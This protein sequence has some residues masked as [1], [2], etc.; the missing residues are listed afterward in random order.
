MRKPAR[1]RRSGRA[2]GEHRCAMRKAAMLTG[3]A[4]LG[5]GALVFL[6]VCYL[7]VAGSLAGNL[8]RVVVLV[9]ALGGVASSAGGL[10]VATRGR[11]ERSWVLY[12]AAVG[13][14]VL[15]YAIARGAAQ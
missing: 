15:W 14:H 9:L 12:C 7:V 8:G 10:T 6:Y 13:L 1:R 5:L 11:A 2:I 4:L 3:T